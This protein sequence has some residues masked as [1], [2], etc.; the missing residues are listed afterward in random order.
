MS[1]CDHIR[2]AIYEQLKGSNFADLTQLRQELS[3]E[4][5]RNLFYQIKQETS[6]QGK[7]VLEQAADGRLYLTFE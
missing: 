4:Q 3:P 5:Q 7:L 1:R 2:L 6:E